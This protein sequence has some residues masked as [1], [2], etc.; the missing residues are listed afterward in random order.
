MFYTLSENQAYKECIALAGLFQSAAMVEQLATQGNVPEEGFET[1]VAS[2]LNLDPE[3]IEDIYNGQVNCLPG[4]S[5]GFAQLQLVFD[6]NKSSQPETLRYVLGLINL[7]GRLS[8]NNEMMSIMRTRLEQL[9]ENKSHFD[10]TH[11]RMI[12]SL[13]S[14]YEDTLSSFNFRI[15]VTGNQLHLEN[16]H[17]VNKIRAM[18]LAGVRSAL[19]WRQIGGKRWHLILNRK[20]LLNTLN[21]LI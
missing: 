8:K 2:T 18:L 6:S 1:V 12:A 5:L 4:L 13:A 14:I 10:I 3:S 21:T 11:E 19:L 15:Q 20:Q 7:Q 17:N 9:V 16:Q